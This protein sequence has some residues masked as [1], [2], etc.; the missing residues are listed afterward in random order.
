MFEWFNQSNMMYSLGIKFACYTSLIPAYYI[1]HNI[2]GQI[3][4]STNKNYLFFANLT[5]N[6]F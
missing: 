6:T 1:H 4:L 2:Q 5:I 3:S